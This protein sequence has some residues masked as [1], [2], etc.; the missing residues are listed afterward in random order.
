MKIYVLTSS[1]FC[2]VSCF[3]WSQSGIQPGLFS[4]ADTR[5]FKEK[6]EEAVKDYYSQ[7]SS[8]VDPEYFDAMDTYVM[9]MER[10]F[11]LSPEV[12]IESDIAGLA[13]G[14]YRLR[15]YFLNLAQI[16][17][18]DSTDIKLNS[19]KASPVYYDS[20]GNFNFIVVVAER[21]L[22]LK[23]HY[24]AGK[25]KKMQDLYFRFDARDNNKI[26]IFSIQNHRE[27]LIT[28]YKEARATGN[29][30]NSISGN[31]FSETRPAAVPDLKPGQFF[32][33]TIPEGATIKF[34]D[35]PDFGTRTTP[36]TIT[37]P[38]G[39][40]HIRISN[41][42][43]ETLE[44][45]IEIGKE[46]TARFELTPTFSFLKLNVIPKDAM[47]TIN[48]QQLGAVTDTKQKTA[49]GKTVIVLSADHY[50]P[51]QIE[52]ETKAGETHNLE[53]KL[54]PKTGLLTINAGN[55]FARGAVVFFDSEMIGVIPF[56][57]VAVQEGRHMIKIRKDKF[58]TQV[59]MEQITEHSEKKLNI[60]FWPAT[61]TKFISEPPR[62]KITINNRL[63]GVSNYSTMLQ[64]GDYS[65]K[66]EKENYETRWEQITIRENEE[67]K[68]FSYTL[69]P[70]KYDLV[71]NSRPVNSSV[72][73]DGQIAGQ[74]P[75]TV[76]ATVGR[77]KITL[78]DKDAFKQT[79]IKRVKPSEHNTFNKNLLSRGF[80]NLNI[81]G[82]SGVFGFELGAVYHRFSVA[83]A[84]RTIK[85]DLYQGEISVS[86][87]DASFSVNGSMTPTGQKISVRDSAGF[88]SCLKLGFMILRPFKMCI[89][90]GYGNTSFTYNDIYK[91]TRTTSLN[92]TSGYINVKEGE[93]LKADP[94]K[95]GHYVAYIV[96]V[97]I[98]LFNRLNLQA[99]CWF[100]TK[101][102]YSVIFGLGFNLFK[103]R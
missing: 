15:E 23:K 78:D 64:A 95:T 20:T 9:N 89:H 75:L 77:H 91:V 17:S 7:L 42:N 81:L 30:E 40:Y 90:A 98:P 21:E 50:H 18:P 100:V 43:Y 59:T 86:H 97:A 12:R 84:I 54:K 83:Y 76:K 74:T 24:K 67:P 63:A 55:E 34:T 32:I 22:V 68:I 48:G 53:V 35:Y 44:T 33:Y 66:I 13:Q 6:A 3:S 4:A 52:L 73:I 46:K 10:E 87:A 51:R 71:I 26:K 60:T 65:I 25:D 69:L 102:N 31:L 99:D 94:V 47:L 103:Q 38:S 56:S 2:L 41:E 29:P 88:G 82:G 37:Y 80:I 19:A 39:K 45:Y 5:R 16:L 85:N 1:L 101:Q 27:E 61:K 93:L 14:N 92:S 8:L 96:G 62:A 28:G 72:Y 49:K 79:F 57:K 58:P 11:F 36:V 70:V